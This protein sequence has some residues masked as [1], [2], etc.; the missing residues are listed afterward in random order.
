MYNPAAE[1]SVRTMDIVYN[2]CKPIYNILRGMGVLPY[3]RTTKGHTEFKIASPAMGYSFLVFCCLFVSKSFCFPVCNNSFVLHSLKT[4]V[5]YVGWNRIDAVRSLGG[6]FEEVVIAYLFIVN[7]LPVFIVP[8]AWY[9]TRKI[10]NVFNNWTD[11]EVKYPIFQKKKLFLILLY[12]F[13]LDSI[14]QDIR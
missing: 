11:F 3:T 13:P 4:Y 1:T 5:G 10:S 9:E 6:H 8:I 2:S 7:I 14:L 12:Y